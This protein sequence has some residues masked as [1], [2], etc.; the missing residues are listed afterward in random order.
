[1]FVAQEKQVDVALAIHSIKEGD[2][3]R[4]WEA[5]SIKVKDLYVWVRSKLLAKYCYRC[6][7]LNNEQCIFVLFWTFHEGLSQNLLKTDFFFCL[8]LTIHICLHVLAIVRLK[9]VNNLDF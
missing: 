4:G 9:R 7:N 2:I 6:N 3:M 5:R 8:L 1:M